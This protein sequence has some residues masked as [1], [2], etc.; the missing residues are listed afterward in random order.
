[1]IG[2][3]AALSALAAILACLLAR[4]KQRIA[5]GGFETVSCRPGTEQK[6]QTEQQQRYTD[7]SVERNHGRTTFPKANRVF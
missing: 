5:L 2:A 4:A 3:L 6:Q 1:M 7:T